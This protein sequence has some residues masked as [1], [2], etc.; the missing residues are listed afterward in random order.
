[1]HLHRCPSARLFMIP[2]CFSHV[3]GVYYVRIQV[4]NI[5]IA[6]RAFGIYNSGIP[7]PQVAR[8][9]SSAL[10]VLLHIMGIDAAPGILDDQNVMLFI[11]F[12]SLAMCSAVS[13]Q[14]RLCS[15]RW[16]AVPPT[17]SLLS[18]L[19]VAH[20]RYLEQHW[21]IL[22]SKQSPRTTEFCLPA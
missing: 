8:I 18:R 2:L 20:N 11:Y 21:D 17:T 19:P 13:L 5:D 9:C 1:M 3:S 7:R 10:Q 12:E 4:L 6:R 15:S 14:F 16:R 22:S